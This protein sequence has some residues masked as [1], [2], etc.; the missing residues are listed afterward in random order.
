M[1]QAILFDLGNVLIDFDHTIAA[2]RIAHFCDKTPQQIFDLFFASNITMLFEEG[3]ITPQDFYQE[4]KKMLGLRLSYE[5]FVPIWN[6]IFFLSSKNLAVYSLANALRANYKTALISNINVLHYEYLVRHFPV[7]RIFHNVFTSFELGAAK[8]NHSIYKKSL[9]TLGVEPENVFYTDD[10][11][12]LVESASQLGIKS[13]L[14]T[15]IEK[16]K[17]DLLVSGVNFN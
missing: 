9:E 3:K 11:A 13:F 14:F 17:K 2:G 4:V 12:E 16:L 10:R 1:I 5:S 7:F 15:D 8:P 6:E